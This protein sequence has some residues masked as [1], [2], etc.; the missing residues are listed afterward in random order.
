M[1]KVNFDI[2]WRTTFLLYFSY[3]GHRRILNAPKLITLLKKLRLLS[4]IE[5]IRTELGEGLYQI[6]LAQRK[7]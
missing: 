1:L 6:V 3:K 4:T 2:K 7:A 5:L